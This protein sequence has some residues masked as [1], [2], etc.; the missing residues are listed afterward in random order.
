M[1]PHVPGPPCGLKPSMGLLDQRRLGTAE[2]RLLQRATESPWGHGCF[3]A[4]QAKRSWWQWVSSV[5]IAG[6]PPLI[7]ALRS[8]RP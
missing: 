2:M 3:P 5:G 8:Q 7:A 6:Q 4:P 1:T